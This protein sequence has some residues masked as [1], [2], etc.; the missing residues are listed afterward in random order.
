MEWK[1]EIQL[2]WGGHEEVKE[3][4]RG[5]RKNMRRTDSYRERWETGMSKN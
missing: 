2:N 1:S 5:K 4:E 3:K